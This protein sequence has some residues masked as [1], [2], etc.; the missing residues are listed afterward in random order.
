MTIT[1]VRVPKRDRHGRVDGFKWVPY[2]WS[3]WAKAKEFEAIVRKEYHLVVR[4]FPAHGEQGV[5]KR[6]E[7]ARG[8]TGSKAARQWLRERSTDAGLLRQLQRSSLVGTSGQ[9]A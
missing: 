7:T 5:V 2:V 1:E 8:V 3:T 4:T 6:A 9:A